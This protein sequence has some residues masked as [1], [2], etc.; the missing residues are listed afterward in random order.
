VLP[1][2][3]IRNTLDFVNG[4]PLFHLYKKA[5]VTPKHL[6]DLVAILESIH[7]TEG[8]MNPNPSISEINDTHVRDNYIKKLEIRFDENRELYDKISP[9]AYNTLQE[10]IGD[11]KKHYSACIVP[12]IHGD[13]WFSNIL[14]TYD[15]RFKFIDMKGQ[16]DGV[17]TVAGDKYY[18]YCKLLQSIIGYDLVLN[19]CDTESPE[20]ASY[21]S[22]MTSD[23]LGL[24]ASKGLNVEFMKCVTRGLIFGTFQFLQEKHG[25]EL[26]R[27]IWKLV[28]ASPI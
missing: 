19:G 8:E 22:Q 4:I 10:I 3:K 21:I 28:V 1:D 16:V 2:G 17:L 11:M 5:L 18:D 7:G 9:D 25:L 12:L 23:Y 13:F 24:C 6:R 27:N 14:F 20:M 26:R 15:D